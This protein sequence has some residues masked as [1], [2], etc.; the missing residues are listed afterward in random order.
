MVTGCRN[1]FIRGGLAFPCGRC[2]P[3]LGARQ[4]VWSHRLQLEAMCHES[5]TFVTLTYADDKLPRTV[6]EVPT[7]APEHVQGWLK[8]IRERERKE[9]RFLRFYLVGEY[10]DTSHRPHYHLV[11]FGFQ[12]CLYG[13][14][15]R[16]PV[17][18]Q[19]RG[20]CC[21]RC[22]LVH[23]TWS[24]GLVELGEVNKDSCDYICKYVLKR[25][26]RYDDPRLNGRNPEFSR[27]SN[28]RGI[29]FG[30]IGVLADGYRHWFGDRDIEVSYAL[31]S[32]TRRKP[33]GR[34]LV[35]QLRIALGRLPGAS[36]ET[37]DAMAAELLPLY[38]RSIDN[39]TSFKKE[40]M[41]AGLQRYENYIARVKLYRKRGSV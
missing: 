4:Q 10:G 28:R 34:Y 41:E 25:M 21:V 26:T 7:L 39:K 3:C 16:D 11:L 24:M 35:N 1:P 18:N 12:P 38:I 8:V 30:H 32:G 29:G 20:D 40:V 15:R 9:G 31:G 37:L 22:R 13:R 33:L 6:D 36:Q 2:E 17:N 23:D 14:T 27:S 19:C 5:S